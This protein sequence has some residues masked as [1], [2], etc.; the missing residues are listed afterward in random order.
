MRGI[1]L[2]SAASVHVA[3]M[4]N[5]WFVQPIDCNVKHHTLQTINFRYTVEC[6]T[7]LIEINCTYTAIDLDQSNI[8]NPQ[9]AH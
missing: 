9:L 4:G 5:L 6:S 2:I 7:Q 8:Y 1:Q 3:H